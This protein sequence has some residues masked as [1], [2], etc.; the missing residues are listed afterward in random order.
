M[1]QRVKSAI[2]H[3]APAVGLGALVILT[4]PSCGK[5][6]E[7]SGQ[8]V[9][10]VNGTEISIYQ[11]NAALARTPGVTPQN[12]E[13]FRGK[14]LDKL[15]DQQLAIGVAKE[16]ELDR[17]LQVIQSLEESKRDILSRS[18]LDKVG[19][20]VQKTSDSEGKAYY[21]AHPE[22]FSNRH[23]YYIQELAMPA[24]ANPPV[25]QLVGMVARQLPEEITNYL[26]DK[27]IEHIINKAVRAA[28]TLSPVA[29]AELGKLKV[30]EAGVVRTGN[31]ISILKLLS[32]QSAPVDEAIAV[33]QIRQMLDNQ[34]TIA[35]VTTELKQLREKG[36]I[37]ITGVV[38]KTAAVKKVVAEE[39]PKAG[40]APRPAAS[41]P[42]PPLA[43][44]VKVDLS[45]QAT[46]PALAGAKTDSPLPANILKGVGGLK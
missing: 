4:L 21:A 43:Y 20:T 34:K 41:L 1:V 29:L 19:A 26:K 36:K 9:A 2:S 3:M 13:E 11:L 40:P 17:T 5:Q 18:Y 28:E 16:K 8:V 46:P 37:E 7:T 14:A 42:P 22:M 44:A 23:V 15:I 25:D 38:G 33:P 10:N 6:K 39:A 35:A 12:A 45:P 31:T 32:S 30:G 24:A 27:K